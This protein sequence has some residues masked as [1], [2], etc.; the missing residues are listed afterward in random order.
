[1]V[2]QLF[3]ASILFASALAGSHEFKFYCE[4]GACDESTCSGIKDITEFT[5]CYHDKAT[6]DGITFL[7]VDTYKGKTSEELCANKDPINGGD[8]FTI[9]PKIPTTWT[10]N[11]ITLVVDGTPDATAKADCMSTLKFATYTLVEGVKEDTFKAAVCT[12]KKVPDEKV[13]TEV[14]WK[15]LYTDKN[16]NSF[17][18]LFPH[19]GNYVTIQGE[20]AK[21]KDITYS[22]LSMQ[23]SDSNVLSGSGVGASVLAGATIAL[24]LS[25]LL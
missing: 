19:V 14:E 11:N 23:F 22:S 15:A 25:A 13:A 24:G 4:S 5:T 21:C 17:T 1:M 12:D 16:T 10:A 3:T 7:T 9:S 2:S 20:A 6:S 8:L 18:F